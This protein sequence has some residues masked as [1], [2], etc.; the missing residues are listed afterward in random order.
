M[1]PL[2]TNASSEPLKRRPSAAFMGR[3]EAARGERRFTSVICVME[4]RHGCARR[5]DGRPLWERIRRELLDRIEI[6]P[7]DE[8]VAEQ[9]AD[10]MA[11][12]HQRG[13]SRSTEDLLIAAT[14]LVYRLTLVTHNVRDFSDIPGLRVEDWM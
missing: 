3:L 7:V 4:M 2:D 12:V 14:G 9:A 1:Y 10:L 8:A 6:L 5:A 11:A 13:R